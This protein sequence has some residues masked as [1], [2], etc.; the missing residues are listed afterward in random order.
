MPCIPP[1]CELVPDI[2]L[3]LI[4]LPYRSATTHFPHNPLPPYHLGE[5][6]PDT[7]LHEVRSLTSLPFRLT[8]LS[9][10]PF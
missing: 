9:S 7:D 5:L 3:G 4:L 6:V 8:P 10:L 1:C 2:D